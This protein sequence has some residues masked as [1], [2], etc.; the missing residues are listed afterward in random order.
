MNKGEFEGKTSKENSEEI[1]EDVSEETI[2]ESTEEIHGELANE[3]MAESYGQPS[4][5]KKGYGR[6]YFFT[7]LA[8]ALA[9]VIIGGL[10]VYYYIDSNIE[11]INDNLGIVKEINVDTSDNLY[12]A[13]AVAE[14]SMDTVVGIVTTEKVNSMLWGTQTYEGMGSGVIVDS[15]GYILTNS[16]V[17]SDGDADTIRVKFID[18]SESAGTLLWNNSTIDLAIVKVDR[19]GLP[20]AEFGDSDDLIIG[21]PVVA[22][23]NPLSL[24]LDRTVT[25]GII[26]GLNRSIQ[27][28]EYTVMEPLIQTDASINPGNSGGPLFNSEGLVIGI[29]TAK[30][31]SAE[32]LGFS[33]PINMAKGIIDEVIENGEV[34]D[35][36][37]GIKGV[38]VSVYEKQ[39]N[40]D[41]TPEYGVVVVEIFKD[42][43]AQTAG[44]M[45]GDVIQEIDGEE[46]DDMSDVQR[47]LFNY[48]PGDEVLMKVIRNGDAV[49]LE[50][51]FQKKPD[52]FN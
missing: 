13:S 3:Q 24:E 43:P 28:D 26:S 20:A 44:L 5:R 18:G 7:A 46:I 16:H 45:A 1:L 19:T 47:Q 14:K 41:L 39:L 31:T 17:I 21:E 48:K 33:I 29:N 40:V 22:I 37:L 4:Y 25:A 30:M 11:E 15:D 10:G 2:G 32:G 49:D 42:S 38:D 34:T 6:K 9:G 27:I 52:N 12:Y 51:V 23:G 35:V 50:L 36:Y 8:G